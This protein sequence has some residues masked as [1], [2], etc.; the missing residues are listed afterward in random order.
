MGFAASL[1][2][3]SNDEIEFWRAWSSLPK[4]ER[5]RFRRRLG[6]ETARVL[7]KQEVSVGAARKELAK[8]VKANVLLRPARGRPRRR[9][10]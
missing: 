3:E 6:T 4:R 2:D 7:K 8:W 1:F 9:G 10:K 5:R